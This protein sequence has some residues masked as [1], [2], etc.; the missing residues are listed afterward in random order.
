MVLPCVALAIMGWSLR[1][2]RGVSLEKPSNRFELSID[3]V[4]VEPATPLEVSQGYD[5]RV[6]VV[7][8]SPRVTPYAARN[9]RPSRIAFSTPLKTRL[10]YKKNGVEHLLQKSDDVLTDALRGDENIFKLR[11][12][13]VPL[14]LGELTLKTAFARHYYYATAKRKEI[15]FYTRPASVAVVVRKVGE[16]VGMPMISRRCLLR[17]KDVKVK[18]I[19]RSSQADMRVSITMESL[20]GTNISGMDGK[21][22]LLNP[23]LV[24]EHGK[25]VRAKKN[26]P[27]MIGLRVPIQEF[28]WTST[29]ERISLRSFGFSAKAIPA[30]IPKVI[31]KAEASVND[32]WPLP[33]SIVVRDNRKPL[34]KVAVKQ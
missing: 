20:D 30:N 33:I 21:C 2:R 24:D 13:R 5:T 14:R 34:V 22:R 10:T 26:S 15:G 11:L 8:S 19:A 4:K 32:C 25:E 1:D 31:F 9:M 3:E 12:S 29:D 27:L 6:V 28:Y 16:A 17:L 18:K 23:R 7:T